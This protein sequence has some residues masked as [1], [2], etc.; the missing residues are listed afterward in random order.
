MYKLFVF[1]ISCSLN[2]YSQS[3]IPVLQE[4]NAWGVRYTDV[5]QP[6][7][8][9]QFNIGENILINNKEYKRIYIDSSP[10]DCY[11][12]EENGVLYLYDSNSTEKEL[13]NF[14]LEVGD[15]FDAP[16][17]FCIPGPQQ[18]F[19]V[20]SVS[21]QF[22]A[23]L[24]RKVI[25]VNGWAD[26]QYWIEGIGSTMGGLYVGEQNIEGGSSLR[27]FNTNGEIYLFNNAT[28]CFLNV[29]GFS[30]NNIFFYPNP[31][32]STSVLRLPIELSVDLVQVYDVNGRLIKEEAIT[33]EYFSIKK[34]DLRSGLYFYQVFSNNKH[35]KTGQFIVK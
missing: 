27:C 21:T 10:M 29:E 34:M 28:D 30:T 20:I 1:L 22:I 17:I 18:S 7:E 16:Y 2:L 8:D 25:E 3:F 13:I 14:N 24:N 6:T 11:V 33:K 26:T 31:I 32:V 35:L 5:Y 23:G 15:T 19:E 12:R 4:G 9:L